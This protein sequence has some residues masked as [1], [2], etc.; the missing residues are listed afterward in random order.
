MLFN[1][2]K[3]AHPKSARLGAWRTATAALLLATVSAKAF[4][5]PLHPTP[6]TNP[7]QGLFL[8]AAKKMPDERFQRTVIL[9]VEHGDYGSLG[10]VLNRP[11]DIPLSEAVTNLT[12]PP[13]GE[14]SIFLGG[15]VATSLI[16]FL[17]RGETPGVSTQPVLGDVGVGFTRPA[18]DTLLKRRLGDDRLRVYAGHAGWSPGQL[19]AELASG[20]WHL[21]HAAP[22]L[23]FAPDTDGLWEGFMR[24]RA[25]RGILARLTSP[26]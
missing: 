10:L 18:L 17:V 16:T 7:E 25:P 22:E 14:L 6:A 12:A 15:P 20:T 23:A 11:T 1:P 26:D 21:F 9:L 24:Y 5:A 8:V 13:G 2:C 3:G 19:Q 4:A